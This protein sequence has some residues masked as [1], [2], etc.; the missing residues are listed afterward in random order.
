MPVAEAALGERVRDG[1]AE[2]FNALY[3]EYAPGIYDFL[4][5]LVRDQAAAEDLTQA[6]FAQA[7]EHRSSLREPAKVRSWLWT[8]AHNLAMNQLGR[9]RRS[10][11]I[12][13]H[14]ELAEFSRGPEETAVAHDAAEL[15]WLAAA[16]LEP[17][18]YAVLDLTVRR[19]LSTQEVAE[20][21][22]V[23]TSHAAVLVH[24]SHEALGNA[25]RYLLVARRRE[26]CEQ[27]AALVPA[28]VR[29]LTPE[30]RS[31]VDHHMRRCEKCRELGQR[32]TAPAELLGALVLI[33]LPQRLARLDW[34]QLL[35]ANASP[36]AP[37]RPAIRRGSAG[38]RFGS[39]TQKITALTSVV[40][41]IGVGTAVWQVHSATARPGISHAIGANAIKPTPTLT[42]PGTPASV[43]A[44]APTIPQP[45]IAIA[46]VIPGGPGTPF[47]PSASSSIFSGGGAT[48]H[49]LRPDGTEQNVLSIA[50][51]RLILAAAGPR[52]FVLDSRGELKGV[53]AAGSVEDLGNLG[54]PQITSLIANS[55]GTRWI[56]GS[57]DSPLPPA[58]AGT[59]NQAPILSS[60]HA[61]GI[62]LPSRTLEKMSDPGG[63]LQPVR[64]LPAGPLIGKQL[65]CCQ[66][67]RGGSPFRIAG[68]DYPKADHFI[69]FD[70]GATTPFTTL[71]LPAGCQFSD[72][73]IAAGGSFACIDS[74]GPTASLDV[75]PPMGPR[76]SVAIPISNPQTGVYGNV[77]F[78]P[79][80]SRV[81]VG[82]SGVESDLGLIP[83]QTFL[84]STKDGTI[85]S[86]A[87]SGV[88][89]V[90]VMP[91]STAWLPDGSL[92][93]T[94]LPGQVG[95]DPGTYVVSPSGNAVKISSG[96]TP[97]GFLAVPSR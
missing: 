83:Y 6:T 93:V 32:L 19:D 30:Q 91:V 87:L 60:V 10:E 71:T 36:A 18:Q 65:V 67:G 70:T 17:R 49:L 46:N 84:V 79:D 90:E 51:N 68:Y 50:G 55:D 69:A 85:T 57:I 86:L 34:S 11:N 37:S 15:V 78:S 5:R 38:R 24:R 39:R 48:V 97:I 72:V 22:G 45:L 61:G 94:R 33:A 13:D 73:A 4:R 56:W 81:A 89:P 26:R 27:L 96:G 8:M 54:T 80:G 9:E 31:A 28:G 44:T 95:G 14:L 74:N 16:S 58:N 88:V 41:V 42:A 40:A 43:P 76:L 12:E 77:Y 62:G 47:D 1:D 52:L 21:L 35:A 29:S 3:E 64:W 92:V 82:T 66:L 25:V 53:T 7:F 59:P 20:A 23:R 75:I 2:A 63:A